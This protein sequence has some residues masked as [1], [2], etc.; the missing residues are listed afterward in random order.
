MTGVTEMP[1]H[2]HNADDMSDNGGSGRS[3]DTPT[4][5]LDEDDITAEVNSIVDEDGNRYQFRTAVDAY[6]RA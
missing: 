1:T 3:F 6:H 4:K 2:D 5:P